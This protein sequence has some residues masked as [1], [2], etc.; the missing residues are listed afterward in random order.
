MRDRLNFLFLN[1]AH[2]LDHL[3]M[4]VFAT[5]AALALVH[6][7]QMSYAELIPYATPGFVA[8]GAFA[9]PAGW[10]ADRWHREGMIA[11]FFVGIGL[12]SMLTALAATPLQSSF[13]LSL[14]PTMMMLF[15]LLCFSL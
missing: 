9:I 10:L 12:A 6:D 2:F 8:F 4:L 7:W 5:V 3:F 15:S 13:S 1:V 11:I 14:S